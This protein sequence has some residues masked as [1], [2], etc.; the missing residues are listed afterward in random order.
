MQRKLIA[1][2]DGPDQSDPLLLRGGMSPIC[3]K[4]IAQRLLIRWWLEFVCTSRRIHVEI[5]SSHDGPSQDHLILRTRRLQQRIDRRFQLRQL[6]CR[7][8]HDC[9]KTLCQQ[10]LRFHVVSHCSYSYRWNAT[11]LLNGADLSQEI[12]TV[13]GKHTDVQK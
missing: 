11:E 10:R 7:F 4:Q 12:H 5:M 8:C 2:R 6:K 13:N 1:R 3:A 9:L